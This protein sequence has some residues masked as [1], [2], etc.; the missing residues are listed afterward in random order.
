[1]RFGEE[2][3]ALPRTGD[4]TRDI[5]SEWV[6]RPGLEH[7][8]LDA[9][10][11]AIRAD[12]RIVAA[13]ENRVVALG[14]V[15]ICA[16]DWRFRSAELTTE[17]AVHRILRGADGWEVDGAARPDLAAC[18]DIDIRLTPFTNTLPIRRLAIPVGETRCFPVAYIHLPGFEVSVVEQEYTAMGGGRVRYRGLSTGFTA[19]LMTDADGIVV[20]Y[21]EIWRRRTTG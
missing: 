20:D 1:M 13:I 18:V 15:V 5:V 8:R 21:G 7:L 16:S 6:G 9:R 14:Y 2:V 10:G 11:A 12:G 4:L 19:M 3:Q 17:D